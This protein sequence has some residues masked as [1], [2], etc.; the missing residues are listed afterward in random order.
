MAK[1]SKPKTS[2]EAE[3][4]KKAPA[5]KPAAPKSAPALMGGI[6]TSLAAETAARM[7]G[8]KFNKAGTGTKPESAMFRQMKAGLNKSS[9]TAVSNLL[10]KAQGPEPV[11]SHPQ[12]KQVGHNQTFGADVSR[13][14]VPRR[15]PG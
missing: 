3:S 14:G 13:S 7:L 15:N 5:K 2:D 11:K 4:K 10:E 6:D 8:A 12:M 1:A 9:T